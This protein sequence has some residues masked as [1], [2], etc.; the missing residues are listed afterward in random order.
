MKKYSNRVKELRL[1]KSL[2]QEQL[3]EKIG[4]TKQAISQYERGERN[5]S[6]TVL[7][8]LRAVPVNNHKKKPPEDL[9][10]PGFK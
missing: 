1:A 9:L 6:M 10:L 4:L 5:P 3:A 8:A 7:D 2:S